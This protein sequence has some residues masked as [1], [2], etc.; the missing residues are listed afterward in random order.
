MGLFD[1][2][3]ESV[4]WKNLFLLSVPFVGFS[5]SFRRLVFAEESRATFSKWRFTGDLSRLHGHRSLFHAQKIMEAGS[6]MCTELYSCRA[7]WLMNWFRS[8]I[9]HRNDR[10]Q[11]KWMKKH[12][13]IK[14]DKKVFH[15][16][17]NR[18]WNNLLG[19]LFIF[20]P[21]CH[22]KR[23]SKNSFSARQFT[24]SGTIYI[25]S[26]LIKFNFLWPNRFRWMNW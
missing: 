19:Y 22:L 15:Y 7:N 4:P 1:V 21:D 26:R 13:L 6:Q 3:H 14:S 12:K 23:Q 16:D 18:F 25:P 10:L 5:Y 20:L 2:Q 11:N 17:C 8:I 9:L 24:P